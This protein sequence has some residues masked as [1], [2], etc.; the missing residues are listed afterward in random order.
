M[1]RL[2]QEK[3][4]LQEKLLKEI[5]ETEEQAYTLA[6]L[7]EDPL[8]YTISHEF[9]Q[10]LIDAVDSLP[11]RTRQAFKLSRISSS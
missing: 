6:D 10:R 11:E 8:E 2:L 1:Y 5:S 4:C 7:G 9:E 3:H